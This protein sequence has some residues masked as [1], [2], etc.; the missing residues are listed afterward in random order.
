MTGSY[1]HWH[2]KLLHPKAVVHHDGMVWLRIFQSTFE[3]VQSSGAIP[4]FTSLNM[5]GMLAMVNSCVGGESC[6]FN[7]GQ[8][9]PISFGNITPEHRA[10]T[11]SQF[12][13]CRMLSGSITSDVCYV[14][15]IIS[16]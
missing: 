6:N 2:S 3:L 9:T 4:D 5:F 13:S 7:H 11:T 16:V 1:Q 10:C 14:C 15:V 12:E 8:A